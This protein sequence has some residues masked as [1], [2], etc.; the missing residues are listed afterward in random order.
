M[1]PEGAA[2]PPVSLQ[3]EWEVLWPQCMGHLPSMSDV[4][5]GAD[6]ANA[7]GRASFLVLWLGSLWQTEDATID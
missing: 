5:I 6:S 2:V 4:K 7:P 3:D 1:G